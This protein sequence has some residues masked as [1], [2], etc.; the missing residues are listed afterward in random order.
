MYTG[1]EEQKRDDGFI[2]S[3]QTQCIAFGDGLNYQKYERNP[4]ITPEMLPEGSSTE[5]FRDPKIWWDEA[6]RCFYAVM[7]SRTADG[8]GAVVLFR[9]GDALRWEYCSTLDRSRNQYGKMW[10]CPDFFPLDGADVLIVSPME[11][12]AE[13]LEFHNGNNAA[14]LTGRWDRRARTFERLE[15]RA[16]DYG[17]DFYAPQTLLT[18][19]G[20][21]VLIGWM[22]SPETGHSQP[23]DIK[24]F[25]QMTIPRELSVRSGRLLQRPVRELERYRGEL[26]ICRNVYVRERLC[27]PQVS[28]RCVDMTVRVRPAGGAL[29]QKF[30]IKIAKD[31][32]FYTAVTYDPGSSVL[33][34]DRS[35]SGFR[36]NIVASRK[37]LVRYQEGE[38]KLRFIIDRFS[39]E[40]FVNDGEQ[41]MTSTLYTPQNADSISFEAEGSAIIDV[42]KY[43]LER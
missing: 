6:D 3:R 42:E 1:V 38:I 10:E 25:G 34:F 31:T 32:E 36:H 14:Y 21:R 33:R 26:V 15:L 5:D 24:W 12:L 37:A 29:Y 8:S 23:H 27:L 20:R 7:G 18:P 28:G 4:V 2:D 35:H 16:L 9:S 22:Q 30:T 41:V 39:A 40:V 17:L 13:G 43:S 11:M 19:D